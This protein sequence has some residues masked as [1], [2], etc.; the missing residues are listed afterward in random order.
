LLIFCTPLIY[1]NNH[2]EN[3]SLTLTP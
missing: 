3:N 2:T 1:K